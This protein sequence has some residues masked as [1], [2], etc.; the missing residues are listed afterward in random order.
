MYMLHGGRFIDEAILL[1][2]PKTK[3][4]SS[5]EHQLKLYVCLAKALIVYL[6]RTP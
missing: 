1:G 2:K 4:K 6:T 5:L 3:T